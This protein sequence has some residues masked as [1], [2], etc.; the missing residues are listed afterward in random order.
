M[1]L[2]ELINIYRITGF[3]L[4]LSADTEVGIVNL[5]SNSRVM[6]FISVSYE[7]ADNRLQRGE[8]RGDDEGQQGQGWC[9]Q[10]TLH[11][12]LVQ[13]QHRVCCCFTAECFSLRLEAGLIHTNTDSS[14]Y[15][16]TS[17][18]ELKICLSVNSCGRHECVV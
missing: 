16:P 7:A 11:Q 10:L 3:F 5:L 9:F 13:Y 8:S 15:V 6:T 12:Q 18:R 4:L 17:H 14:R 2:D 1:T